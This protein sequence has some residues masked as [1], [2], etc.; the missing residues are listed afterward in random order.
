MSIIMKNKILKRIKVNAFEV[1]SADCTISRD[2][3]LDCGKHINEF[4]LKPKSYKGILHIER[5]MGHDLV[6]DV[7]VLVSEEDRFDVG[8][9]DADVDHS[10]VFLVLAR[11]LVLLDLAGSVVIRVGA[12]D[13]AVLRPAFHCLGIYIVALLGIT[14]EPSLCLPLLEVAHRLVI[15]QRVVVLEDRVEINLGLGDV[16]QRFLAGHVLGFY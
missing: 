15:Y 9:L 12:E 16:E 6:E 4:L 13:E 14:L 11:Q 10:V 1:K 8:V 5:I 7:V 2:D 3:T